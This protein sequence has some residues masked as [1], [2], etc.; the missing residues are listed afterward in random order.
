MITLSKTV[1]SLTKVV[2]ATA[3]LG[4]S[5]GASAGIIDDFSTGQATL[6]DITV[7]GTYVSSSVGAGDP[8][9]LGGNRDIGVSLISSAD[10]ANINAEI[11]VSSVTGHLN[12]SVDTT[13]TATGHVDWD[14]AANT[15]ET[16]DFTG[17]GGI[18]I[19]AGG[20]LTAFKV[21]T[22][23]ADAGFEFVV[24]AWTDANNWTAISFSATGTAVP[25]TTFIPFSAFENVALC[26]AV[27]PA[28]GV[29][30]ITCGSGNTAPVDLSNLGALALDID[31]NGGTVSIDLTLDSISTVPEPATVALFGTGLLLAGGLA[32]FRRRK[33]NKSM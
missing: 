22:I 10:P 9:I 17:L 13:A 2:A 27:N 4:V 31:P 20:T 19:T 1:H 26:G 29:N 15:D 3:L 11:G 33:F 8:T 28:P 16:V 18:D 6:V 23:F 7:D 14:G 21:D 5:M 32:G 12:F 25:L 24:T 30:S